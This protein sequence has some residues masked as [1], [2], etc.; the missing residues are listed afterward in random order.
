MFNSAKD[1][2]MNRDHYPFLVERHKVLGGD[3]NDL[4]HYPHQIVFGL[5]CFWGA[6]RLFW[7]LKGVILT[8]VGYAGGHTPFPRYDEVCTG[9]TDHTEVVAI[10][11]DPDQISLS[12][13]LKLFWESHDPTQGMRQG[14]DQGSQYRSAI[15]CRTAA[16]LEVAMKSKDVY[17]ELLSA[18]DFPLITTE[19]A[20]NITFYFAEPYHQ[21]Y[22]HTNPNGYCGLKGTGV[23]CV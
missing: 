13:L 19:I 22:L 9:A 16:E 8:A 15:Y 11:Y 21:Q 5:G 23:V 12:E 18:K 3:L 10:A 4:K 14:N 7:S 1:D 17:Q 2:L 6:E 20:Q